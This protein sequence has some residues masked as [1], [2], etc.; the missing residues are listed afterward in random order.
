VWE[1]VHGDIPVGYDVHHKNDDPTDDRLSNLVLIKN[2]MHQS[3]HSSGSHNPRFIPVD[4]AILIEI[5][6]AIARQPK[7]D[8]QVKIRR[9]RPVGG[10]ITCEK[11]SLGTVP[12]AQSP[13]IGGNIQGLPWDKFLER[14]SLARAL[15]NDTYKLLSRL[16]LLMQ[17]QFMI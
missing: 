6:D 4:D 15:V 14:I 3:Q 13:T 1:Q 11:R 9:L 2:G 16:I 5:Y 8:T 12:M 17:F 10:M 7:N